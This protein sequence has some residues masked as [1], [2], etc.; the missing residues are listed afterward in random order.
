M[1]F[2]VGDLHREAA[3]QNLERALQLAGSK[4]DLRIR[5][6]PKDMASMEKFAGSALSSIGGVKHV[7]IVGDETMAHHITMGEFHAPDFFNVFQS[8]NGIL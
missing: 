2:A 6:H 7:D 4:T 3:V 5:V 8:I 1:T